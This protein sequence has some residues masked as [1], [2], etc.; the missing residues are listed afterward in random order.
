[1]ARGATIVGAAIFTAAVVAGL[2][3]RLAMYL[4]R[5]ANPSHNGEVTH[6]N[7]ITGQWTMAGTLG[8]VATAMFL[9][10]VILLL[11]A[12]VRPVL[13]IRR[14][15]RLAASAVLFTVVG[16]PLTIDPES[17]ELY[18][19]VSPWTAIALFAALLPIGGIV[20][21][22]LA[23]AGGPPRSVR[24]QPA[25]VDVVWSGLVVGLTLLVAVLDVVSLTRLPVVGT[26]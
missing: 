18:R 10:P 25:A 13:P 19:Y 21:T 3:G 20:M 26:G 1:V 14:W 15:A 2:G 12:V 8:L 5:V 11:Y 23:E 7:A 16:F 6:A 9:A 22:L 24:V 4:V 17:Y